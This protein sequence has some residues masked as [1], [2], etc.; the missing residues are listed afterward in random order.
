M[1]EKKKKKKVHTEIDYWSSA[2]FVIHSVLLRSVRV[3]KL[4]AL[5]TLPRDHKVFGSNPT[6]GGIQLM[7][8]YIYTRGCESVMYLTSLGRPTDIGLQLGKTC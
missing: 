1:L 5:P 7:T 4:L 2:L 6:G 3:A 8:I